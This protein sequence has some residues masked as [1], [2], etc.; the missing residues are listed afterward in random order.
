LADVIGI[1][2]ILGFVW[3]KIPDPHIPG[4]M[5]MMGAFFLME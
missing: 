2:W 1:S 5:N 4:M 3:R